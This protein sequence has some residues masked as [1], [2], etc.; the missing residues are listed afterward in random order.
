V[1]ECRRLYDGSELAKLGAR[2]LELY[3]GNVSTSRLLMSLL[4]AAIEFNPG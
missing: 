3:L 1:L 2:V 4:L